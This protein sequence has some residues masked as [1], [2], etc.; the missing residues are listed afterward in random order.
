MF[1]ILVDLTWSD[2]ILTL[3]L[4]HLLLGGAPFH[5]CRPDMFRAASPYW[6]IDVCRGSRGVNDPLGHPEV[7]EWFFPSTITLSCHALPIPTSLFPNYPSLD[8]DAE[9]HAHLHNIRSLP[10]AWNRFFDKSL[11]LSLERNTCA[12]VMGERAPVD[13]LVPSIVFDHG[14]I[15]GIDSS[16]FSEPITRPLT[17]GEARVGILE[18]GEYGADWISS[19]ARLPPGAY[20]KLALQ[21]AWY[22]TRGFLTATYKTAL[23]RMF[24]AGRTECVRSASVEGL[25]FVQAA[26]E[27]GCGTEYVIEGGQHEVE[28]HPHLLPPPWTLPR[29]QVPLIP[30][31]KHTHPLSQEWKLS[32]SCLSSGDQFRGTGLEDGYG[33]NYLI[34]RHCIKFCVESKLS[35]SLTSTNKFK[36]H[37]AD[38]LQDARV[39]CEAGELEL[40]DRTKKS[41]DGMGTRVHARL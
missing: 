14:V 2:D 18:F 28:M 4:D 17:S 10:R 22:R 41:V 12:S 19:V 3:Y 21:L 24:N 34:A 40:K 8:S 32:T 20:T 5:A 11:T 36:Q 7:A 6:A 1:A 29:V 25:D 15:A 39:I 26:K 27:W 23:T 31:Q 13:T 38:A 35:F 37:I 9:I 30:P 33:I 16:A